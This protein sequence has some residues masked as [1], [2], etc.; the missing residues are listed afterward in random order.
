M[1]KSIYGYIHTKVS[2]RWNI[3]ALL[4]QED[5]LYSLRELHKQRKL[6]SCEDL[7]II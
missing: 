1:E 7:E 6:K 2:I 4:I 5:I 3:S